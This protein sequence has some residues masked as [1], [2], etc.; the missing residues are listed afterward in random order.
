MPRR[1]QHFLLLIAVRAI[2]RPLRDNLR[3]VENNASR[4]FKFAMVTKDDKDLAEHASARFG[5]LVQA[6][7]GYQAWQALP[8]AP[9]CRHATS[10]LRQNVDAKVIS[11]DPRT[12]LRL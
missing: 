3:R 10:L 12:K 7:S 4:H 9:A 11:L 1:Q 8:R 2:S 6:R 5:L